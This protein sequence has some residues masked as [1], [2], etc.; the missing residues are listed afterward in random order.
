[1]KKIVG[2]SFVLS[3]ALAF[4]S[5]AVAA[6]N[7]S[8]ATRVCVVEIAKVLHDSPSVK[9]DVETL[10]AQFSKDQS[11]IEKKQKDLE[12]RVADLKKN[13]AVMKATDKAQAEKDIATDRQ[14]LIKEVT[15]FQQKLTAAQK[16]TM[17][18]VFKQLNEVIQSN[19][20]TL[21]CDVVLDSQ[22]VLWA[23]AKHDITMQVEKAF[24]SKSV[25][26]AL[27]VKK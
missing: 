2:L 27:V 22:F 9:K 21:S 3:A 5:V 19:A 24:D 14:S 12:S 20:K 7:T 18:V 25:E 10:K 16:K 4:S 6:D 1:M 26:K 11:A 8:T 13:A 15:E 17:D 23:D